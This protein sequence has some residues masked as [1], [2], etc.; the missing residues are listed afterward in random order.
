MCQRHQYVCK[1]YERSSV[2]HNKE[3]IEIR[4]EQMLAHLKYE[5]NKEYLLY[6]TDTPII[7]GTVVNR[8]QS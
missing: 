6:R 1:F 4:D 2:A 7:R 8:L 5:F 3:L